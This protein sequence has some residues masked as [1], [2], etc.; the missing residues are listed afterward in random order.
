M[1]VAVSTPGSRDSSSTNERLKSHFSCEGTNAT[2]Q[3]SFRLD[4][5]LSLYLRRISQAWPW[6]LPLL[7]LL[8]VPDL[9][10][11]L[12]ER[13]LALFGRDFVLRAELADEP[14]DLR[15]P[16]ELLVL[17]ADDLAP[18][19][20]DF[21]DVPVDRDAELFDAPLLERLAVE[22]EPV[23]LRLPVD[24]DVDD[25]R[26]VPEAEVLDEVAVL[27]PPDASVLHFPDMTR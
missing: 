12:R 23:D 15:A 13:E 21:L 9:P 14:D 25:L 10:P 22:R 24:R 5:L 20:P 6:G 2:R 7:P 17:L 27:L 16:D 1:R 26:A 3:S 4:C 19:V 11:L 8:A 18:L